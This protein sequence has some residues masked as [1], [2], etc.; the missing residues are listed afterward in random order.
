MERAC[1]WVLEV[2]A[3]VAFFA[4]A[5]GALATEESSLELSPTLQTLVISPG[6]DLVVP[7]TGR[8]S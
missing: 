7:A 6:F 5:S 3:A 4:A 8:P 2:L 1:I